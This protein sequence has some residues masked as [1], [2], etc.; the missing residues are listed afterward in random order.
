MQQ[1]SFAFV[2]TAYFCAYSFYLYAYFYSDFNEKDSRRLAFANMLIKIIHMPAYIVI[3]V[4]GVLFFMTIFTFAFSI[5][6]VL[7]DLAAIFMTGLIGLAAN[8]VEHR[9][10]ETGK[11]FAVINSIL[12]FVYCADVV[13]AIMVFTR[14][15]KQIK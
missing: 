9:K 15:R 6:F 12:Q 3:F 10:G 14:S 13:S 7:F 1:W 8:S 4:L 2:G 5:F 11:A